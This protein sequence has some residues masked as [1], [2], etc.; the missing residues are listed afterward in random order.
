MGAP[1]GESR[2]NVTIEAMKEVAKDNK[3]EQNAEKISSK[4]A[5]KASLEEAINPFAAKVKQKRKDKSKLKHRI[6]KMLQ[7][8]DK[9]GKK[10]EMKKKMQ[11]TADQFQRRNPELKS[12]ALLMLRDKIKPDDT[13]EDILRKL[14]EFYPDVSLSDEALEFLLETTDNG[15]LARQVLLAK[16]KLNKENGTEIIAGR[17]VTIQARQASESG[18]GT[19]TSMRDMYRDVV[20]NPRDPNEL[21][22]EL[23]EKYAFKDLKKVADFLLHSLGADMKSKGPS[24]PRGE[25][26]RL[27]AETRSLQSILGV[28][29]FFKGR[30]RL[31]TSL[32]NKNG[33]KLPANLT[34][35]KLAKEF[36]QLAADRYPSSDK[37][38][39]TAGRLGIEKWILAKIFVLSQMRDAVREVAMAQIFK[40]IQRR[41]ET[42]LALL[43]ALEDLEDALEEEEDEKE[44]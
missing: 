40:T 22:K 13:A 18:L 14:R 15:E 32:F 7:M 41:D 28:Y 4:L 20:T 16:E 9:A 27:I 33:I 29:R 39:V 12:K 38:M 11:D 37:A 44:R 43:E 30:M 21:F 10:V 17:N 25:L 3:A 31:L 1:I 42:Y 5:F 8:K 19:P 34:F 24:I 2:S 35:E 26:H 6:Q 36:M 23:S